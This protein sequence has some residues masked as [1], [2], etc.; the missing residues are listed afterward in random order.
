MAENPDNAWHLDRRVPIAL[1][2]TLAMQ[3]SV[4]I[5]WMA[6]LGSRV[7]YLERGVTASSGLSGEII[8]IK[9]QL[10]GIDRTL[11]RLEAYLDRK[12]EKADREVRP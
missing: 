9:E 4:G 8:Q 3:G 11:T 7:D 5:W 6:S 12:A 1:I 2:V 10:R